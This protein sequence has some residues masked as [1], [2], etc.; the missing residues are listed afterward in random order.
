MPQALA[1]R[2]ARERKPTERSLNVLIM[3]YRSLY[4]E[5]A[6]RAVNAAVEVLKHGGAVGVRL[7]EA[8]E[9]YL[10]ALLPLLDHLDAIVADAVRLG[11][12]RRW[13]PVRDREDIERLVSIIVPRVRER[14]LGWLK[15]MAS[16]FIRTIVLPALAPEAQAGP[17]DAPS[18]ASV[19]AALGWEAAEG[20]EFPPSAFTVKDPDKVYDFDPRTLLDL[21]RRGY[22]FGK[23]RAVEATEHDVWNGDDVAYIEASRE[24]GVAEF[25]WRTSEDAVVCPICDELEG[26]LYTPGDAARASEDRGLHSHCR[27]RCW[28]EA[29]EQA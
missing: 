13:H 2:L 18:G 29:V 3:Q 25:M 15:K 17:G 28:F 23:V 1:P 24:D 4:D 19:A 5:H 6:Q 10:R 11:A 7:A 14:R 22:R 21:L 27:C 8:R 12:S 9:A 26:E 20:G 16:D